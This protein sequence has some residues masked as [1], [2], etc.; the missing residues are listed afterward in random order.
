[1]STKLLVANLFLGR[2]DVRQ[3]YFKFYHFPEKTAQ[4]TNV[5]M[6]WYFTM[7]CDIS[8]KNLNVASILH[9]IKYTE[10]NTYF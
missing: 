3:S 8:F 10:T 2:T 1:M 7:I 9:T 4:L 6:S 5:C